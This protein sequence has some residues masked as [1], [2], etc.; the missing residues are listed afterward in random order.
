[1][2][3]SRTYRRTL[4]KFTESQS[5]EAQSY[6]QGVKDAFVNVLTSGDDD[7]WTE[8]HLREDG[9]ASLSWYVDLHSCPPDWPEAPSQIENS[10]D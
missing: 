8:F 7:H 3:P 2:Q 9:N 6:N 4:A 1:M 5:L 10:V